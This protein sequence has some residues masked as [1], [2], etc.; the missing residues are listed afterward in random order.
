M[1]YYCGAVDRSQQSFAQNSLI[2][3]YKFLAAAY[4]AELQFAVRQTDDSARCGWL[5]AT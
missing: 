5:A 3:M 1:D 4:R 2:A